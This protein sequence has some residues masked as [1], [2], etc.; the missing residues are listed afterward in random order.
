MRNEKS[1]E[2]VTLGKHGVIT[3]ENHVTEGGIGS[4]VAETMA[5]AGVAKRLIRLGLKDTYAHGG[6]RPYLMRVWQLIID[7]LSSDR[8]VTTSLWISQGCD[9]QVGGINHLR[10][11]LAG[12]IQIYQDATVAPDF[13]LERMFPD[14][15]IVKHE[16]ECSA[17][18][19]KLIAVTGA[20]VS[21]DKLKRR[22]GQQKVTK[23]LR[24]QA[25]AILVDL[26]RNAIPARDAFVVT[27]KD[28][29]DDLVSLLP[30][31]MSVSDFLDMK[32]EDPDFKPDGPVV[33]HFGALTGLD[34]FGGYRACYVIGDPAFWQLALPH[35]SGKQIPARIKPSR[36]CSP[37]MVRSL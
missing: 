13:A 9:L 30:D 24:N 15:K 34:Y 1:T 10:N 35:I 32:A 7:L 12:A 8:E 31:A 20:P 26:E 17:P 28:C 37:L 29:R 25:R 36:I 23:H 14:R 6:S 5:D 18:F 22:K 3:L 19:E 11:G 4:L 33:G 21:K 16:I 2:E 27:F